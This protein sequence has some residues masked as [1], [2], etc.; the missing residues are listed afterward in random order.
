MI[1]LIVVLLLGYLAGCFQSAYIIGKTNKHIDIRQHGSGNAGTTNA[2]RVM[3]FKLGLLTFLG[4]FLKAFLMVFTVFYLTQNVLS[5][6]FAGLGVILGHDFPVFLNFKGGKG[7]ASTV[8]VA[9]ALDYRAGLF[10]VAVM[11]IMVAVS[12]YVSVASI[13]LCIVFPIFYALVYSPGWMGTL[14][15]IGIG[16]LGIYQHR[17][18]IQRLI[19]GTETKLQ[20]KKKES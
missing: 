10:C 14:V 20:F 15:M 8:G 7:I 2:L 1:E 5:A 11:V 4:D 17:T 19:T 12:R 9:F 13:S 3:G 18:N 16:L 6:L